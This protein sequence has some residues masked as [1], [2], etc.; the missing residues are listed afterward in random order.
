MKE[1]NSIIGGSTTDSV[2]DVNRQLGNTTSD[3]G[4][5]LFYNYIQ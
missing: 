4:D 3:P 2:T 5:A 1:H